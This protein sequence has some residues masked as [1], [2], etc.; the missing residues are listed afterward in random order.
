MGLNI[1]GYSMVYGFTNEDAGMCQ[2]GF[3]QKNGHTYFIK[4]FLS[5]KYPV[6]ETK[7]GPEL[8]KAMREKADAYYKLKSAFYD[9][10]RTCRTGNIVVVE[11]FFRCGAKYY[12][13][14]DKICGNILSIEEIAK[15]TEDKKRVLTQSI[16]YSMTQ[17]HNAGI[18]HSDLKPENILVKE[19][20]SGYCT[21]K[22]IDFDA[23]FLEENVPKNIEG[24]QN[25]FSPEAIQ[26]TND[27]DVAVTTK[28]DVF[29]LGL[30]I[31]QYWTG[32][33]PQFSKKYHYAC[34]AVLD[35]SPVEAF[36]SIPE[37][38]RVTIVKMLSKSPENR[39]TCKEA[40]LYLGEKKATTAEESTPADNSVI[41]ETIDDAS[42]KEAIA[43]ERAFVLTVPSY[44]ELD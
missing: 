32:K 4:E 43:E 34:E 27:I 41:A 1:N 15:L 6:D 18:V 40:W 19:T 29:A 12:A 21:A 38:V 30:L 26:K 16:L 44:T 35:N 42:A 37:D 11:D 36:A 2:W 3:A 5:P 28:A 8:T 20:E 25:Y 31:H 14:T 33:M 22:I 7:L 24:S 13:V 39:P 17:L 23:G 10:L 9:T